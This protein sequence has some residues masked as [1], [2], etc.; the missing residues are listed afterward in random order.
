MNE[1]DKWIKQIIKAEEK[2]KKIKKTPKYCKIAKLCDHYKPCN[3]CDMDKRFTKHTIDNW[4]SYI[5]DNLTDKEYGSKIDPLLELLN[6][7]EDRNNVLEDEITRC[8]N[9]IR[10]LNKAFTEK[11]IGDKTYD[12]GTMALARIISIYLYTLIT[13]VDLH[14]EN[15]HI[16]YEDWTYY[17]QVGDAIVRQLTLL[18]SIL[19]LEE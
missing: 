5:I 4:E 11:K 10:L 9:Q 6:S 13:K 3:L 7:L 2:R 16:T 15:G 18:T 14:L 12:T 1:K 17:H 8:Q 19:I